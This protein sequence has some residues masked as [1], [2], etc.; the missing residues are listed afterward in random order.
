M[1]LFLAD[2]LKP[3]HSTFVRF[4]KLLLEGAQFV[5]VRLLRLQVIRCQRQ[6]L[7][8]IFL[9]LLL[10]VLVGVVLLGNHRDLS[11]VGVHRWSHRWRVTSATASSDDLN[12]LTVLTLVIIVASVWSSRSRPAVRQ[13]WLRRVRRIL[14][15]WR[16]VPDFAEWQ[17]RLLTDRVNWQL[18]VR[19]GVFRR[20]V[21]AGRE[22]EVRALPHLV[23]IRSAKLVDRILFDFGDLP[24]QRHYPLLARLCSRRAS[25]HGLCA[26]VYRLIGVPMLMVGCNRM[27]LLALVSPSHLRRSPPLM[28]GLFALHLT[29]VFRGYF[30]LIAILRRRIRQIHAG[31]N[32]KVRLLSLELLLV[33]L[34]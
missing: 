21:H 12:I 10:E 18:L 33:W 30:R 14:D 2:L 28:R 27:Q 6:E 25:I 19:D 11:G 22:A 23:Q 15:H 9:G 32:S 4:F 16:H 5:F 7:L 8:P 1:H 26:Q 20:G 17:G 34:G 31:F 3:A 24:L 29:Q 13:Y